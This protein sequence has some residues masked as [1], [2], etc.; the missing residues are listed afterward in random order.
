MPKSEENKT[1]KSIRF[2]DRPAKGEDFNASDIVA[3]A[4]S[5][6]LFCDNNISDAL[7][8][9]RITGPKKK[10]HSIV[11]RAIQ[12][13]NSKNVDDLE[14]LALAVDG[15]QKFIFAITSLSKRKKNKSEEKLAARSGL[16]RIAIGKQ[17][18]LK[19]DII[20]D[21]RS[22][23]IENVPELRKVSK[24]SA[25]DGGINLEG[26]CWYPQ[27]NVLM[28]GFRTPLVKGMPFIL[29]IRLQ[30]KHLAIGL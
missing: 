30:K 24:N 21:F 2:E 28:L 8:E 3:L 14:G 7:F 27:K 13:M 19:A 15:N 20:P 10:K 9:L 5:T 12:G 29:P 16:V 4:D 26:L 25:E 23:L 18:Q 22:W 6:F 1:I 11:K 17:D